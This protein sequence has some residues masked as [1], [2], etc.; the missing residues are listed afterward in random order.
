MN[1]YIVIDNRGDERH[2]LAAKVAEDQSG[3]VKFYDE[4]DEI[5]ASFVGTN[6]YWKVTPTEG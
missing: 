4:S 6:G 3:R 2:I 1:E 5:V